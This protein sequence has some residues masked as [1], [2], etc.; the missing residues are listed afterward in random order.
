MV[1]IARDGAEAV[2]LCARQTP[3]LVLMDLIM[4]VMDGVEATRR[5]MASTP[6][7]ILVVTVSVRTNAERVFEAMGHGALDAIDTPTLGSGDAERRRRPAAGEDR[8]HRPVHRQ[9]RQGPHGAREKWRR[10]Q[11]SREAL[12][13][14]GASAGGPT[15]LSALLGGL[16]RDFRLR[17]S[18]SSTSTSGSL[19]A[20]P[21]GS[22]EAPRFRCGLREKATAAARHGSAGRHRR[23]SGLQGSGPARLYARA[24]RLCLP[25][26]RRRLLSERRQALAGQSGRRPA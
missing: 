18:S 26:L 4:P 11:S 5:I 23:P 14:I 13:A 21:N 17:S 19:P 10:A 25:S 15:A 7:S 2:E 9:W 6:C 1:W 16:P 3:D 12:V 8:Q 24:G 22:A 20:W